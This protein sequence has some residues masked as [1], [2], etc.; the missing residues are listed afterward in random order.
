MAELPNST[1][2]NNGVQYKSLDNLST[3]VAGVKPSDTQC[4]CGP[5]KPA[6]VQR[7]AHPV[8]FTGHVGLLIA[9]NFSALTYFSGILTTIERQFKLSSSEVAALTIL[10][11]VSILCFILFATYFGEKGHR[12]RWIACGALVVAISYIVCSL[13]HF[14]TDPIDPQSLIAGGTG[15]GRSSSETTGVCTTPEFLAE[16]QPGQESFN[17]SIPDDRD[18]C[19]NSSEKDGMGSVK[20]VVIGQIIWGLGS[21][22]MFPLTLSYIDDSVKRHKFT[23]YTGKD[24]KQSFQ[25]KVENESKYS[26]TKYHLESTPLE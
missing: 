19:Q 20:W 25:Y 15:T 9:I 21:A 3:N 7:L 1:K 8:I 5:C 24:T 4:G 16:Y 13:P 14:L 6:F 18:K 23:S 11:D 12:P 10:N 22:P 26:I 2:H 17:S